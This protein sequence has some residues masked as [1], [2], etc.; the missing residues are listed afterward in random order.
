V[1]R[2]F[3]KLDSVDVSSTSPKGFFL[4]RSPCQAEFKYKVQL[5]MI[6]IHNVTHMALADL[7]TAARTSASLTQY[8]HNHSTKMAELYIKIIFI[9]LRIRYIML[10]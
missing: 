3:N 1:G 8:N 6:T 4:A 5:H 9:S 10:G 2:V 7:K